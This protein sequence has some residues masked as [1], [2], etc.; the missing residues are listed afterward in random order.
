MQLPKSFTTDLPRAA[1][2]QTATAAALTTLSPPN[3]PR[4]QSNPRHPERSR[5]TASDPGMHHPPRT[6]NARIRGVVIG[7]SIALGFG[8][9]RGGLG[10]LQLAFARATADRPGSR[11]VTKAV[12]GAMVSDVI[13]HQLEAA[14]AQRP[15]I[16]IVCVGGNDVLHQTSPSRMQ[17]EYTTLL[18][19][20]STGVHPSRIVVCGVPDVSVSPLFSDVKTAIRRVSAVDNAVVFAAVVAAGAAFI[21]IFV[22]MQHF[23][24][25]ARYLGADFFHP[26]DRG[27]AELASIAQPVIA[28]SL[29]TA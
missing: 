26:S 8:A 27:Y 15:D 18:H 21:D 14:I 25:A 10:F 3:H 19:R 29:R 1:F 11:L 7:D 24:N 28:K 23:R 16:A 12:G 9:S 22:A 2:L 6:D 13:A 17:A 20:L 5:G 4:P